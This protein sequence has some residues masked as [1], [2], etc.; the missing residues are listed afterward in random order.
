MNRLLA[1]H[2]EVTRPVIS[3]VFPFEEARQAYEHLESQAHVGKIV[4]KVA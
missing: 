4:I 3:K 1:L 2:P